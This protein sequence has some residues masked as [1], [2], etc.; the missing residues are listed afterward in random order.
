MMVYL[1]DETLLV[2]MD[3]KLK[4]VDME[5]DG[6]TFGFVKLVIGP[7]PVLVGHRIIRCNQNVMK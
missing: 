4:G 2:P 5:L 1:V 3:I 7:R 6:K